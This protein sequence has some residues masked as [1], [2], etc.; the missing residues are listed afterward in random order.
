MLSSERENM[1]L[2]AAVEAER[3]KRE[4]AE[5]DALRLHN[6]KMDFFER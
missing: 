1:R 3:Q 5:A 2:R 6:E 4:D